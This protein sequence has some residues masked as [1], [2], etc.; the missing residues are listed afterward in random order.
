ML[1]K[2]P[3]PFT[4]LRIQVQEGKI[5]KQNAIENSNLLFPQILHNVTIAKISFELM[6]LHLSFC[7]VLSLST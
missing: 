5:M 3:I 1:K 4:H 7:I 2:T 6:P